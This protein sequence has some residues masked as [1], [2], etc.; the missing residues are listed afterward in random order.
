M[1]AL[2]V[3]PYWPP[4]E[5]WGEDWRLA[6]EADGHR[7]RCVGYRRLNPLYK[8]KGLKTLYQ[9]WIRRAILARAVEWRPDLVLVFKGESLPPEY[10]RAMKRATG[11]V[12]VNVFVDNPLFTTPFEHI[13]PYDL[14]CTKEPYAI[15]ALR[16]VGL[17]NLHY[18]PCHCSPVVDRAPEP[19][20]EERKR[21]AVEIGFTG[22]YYPYRGRFFVELKDLPIRIWGRGWER[23]PGPVRHLVAGRPVWGRD[24]LLSFSLPR[25]VLNLHHP[26]NDILGVNDRLFQVASCGGFQLT[27]QREDVG[28]MFTEGKEIVTYRDA[29]ECRRRIEYYL[30]HPEERAEI[31]AA[32]RR[33][34]HQD[35]TVSERLRELL[36]ALRERSLF[37]G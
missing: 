11:A 20:P 4:R 18:L 37:P 9:R 1:R 35:H 3:V 2:V 24:K 8:N 12:I 10:I 16:R 27:D 5:G 25:I 17:G 6:L 32:G 34:A 30:A 23:A 13:E 21:F 15:E 26:L 19:T 22:N 14:F 28:R 33:R 7:V 31:A 29:S 36:A